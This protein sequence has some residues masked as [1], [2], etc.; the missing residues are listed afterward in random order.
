MWN[1]KEIKDQK[2][3][4]IEKLKNCINP[5]EQERL[6]LT[7]VSYLTMLDNS[8]TIRYTKIP[9]IIDNFAN[10]K[11]SLKRKKKINK[12]QF[13]EVNYGKPTDDY[14]SFLMELCDNIL[15]TKD[16]YTSDE[17]FSQCN[18]TLEELKQTSKSFYQSLGDEEILTKANKVLEDDSC[19]TITDTVRKGYERVGGI[20]FQDSVFDKTYISVVKS[21]NLFEY[22]ALNHEVMHGIDFLM[23]KNKMPSKYHEGF[24]EI[25]TYTIDYFFI[26]YLESLNFPKREVQQL[27]INKDSYLQGLAAST[28]FRI[29]EEMRM[30][31]AD[32]LR[33]Y[34]DSHGHSEE[35]YIDNPNNLHFSAYEVKDFLKESKFCLGKLLELESGVVSYGLYK[36]IKENKEMGLNSLKELMRNPLPK[37]QIPDF[38]FINLDNNTL[39]DLSKEIGTFSLEN[40]HN[41]EEAP[42]AASSAPVK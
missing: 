22:Q 28:K 11:L 6:E 15:Q 37:D 5:Q 12:L 20:A 41:I 9:N 40:G 2:I 27:R 8:G 1:I 4:V 14:V 3:Y 23:S 35:I 18:P 33:G 42:K 21:N 13:L 24:H 34:S 36:Q 17:D 29:K 39:L 38:S 7:L 10:N 31:Y 16:C 26:D 32:S 25:P 30:K 19:F